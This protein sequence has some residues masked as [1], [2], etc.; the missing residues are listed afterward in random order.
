MPFFLDARAI[1]LRLLHLS[2]LTVRIVESF[3]QCAAALAVESTHLH[4]D[5]ALFID[6]EVDLLCHGL[7]S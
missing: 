3:L 2:D 6:F 5:I 4:C 1:V 7:A